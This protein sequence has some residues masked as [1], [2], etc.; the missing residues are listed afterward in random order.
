MIHITDGQTDKI[1][2][3]ITD[4][5]ILSNNHRQSLKDM[6]ETFEFETF[7][8]KPFSE[9]LGDHNRVV[10][11]NEDRGYTEFVIHEAAKFRDSNGSL[12]AEV[13]AS[14]SY[15]L[16][17]KA[18]VIE[19]QTLS[20]YTPS[21]AAS[22]TVGDTEWRT[23]TIEGSGYRTFHIENHTNPFALLKR[24]AREFELE[25]RFRVEVDGNRITGRFVDLLERVGK[26]RG[27]EVEFGRD[28]LGIRR[29]EKTDNIVTALVGL[30]PVREDG[31]RLEVLVEDQEALARWG[32]N[33]QHL[34]EVYEPQSTRSDMTEEELTQ[35]TRTELDKRINAVVEYESD[36]A[37]LEN[38]PGMENKKIR[39]GDTIKIKD[40]KFNPP[41]YLEARVHTQ[42]RDIVDKSNKHVE[43]GDF[44]EYTEEEVRSIWQELQ[45]EIRQKVSEYD[46]VEYTY[47]KGEIDQKDEGVYLDG[48]QY[49]D[50]V[51]ETAEERAKRHAEEEAKREAEE[52][53]QRAKEY[54]VAKE[55]YDAK[56]AEL[57][58]DIADKTDFEYVDGQ[59]VLK[60]DDSRV[61]A[62]DSTVGDLETTSNNLLQRV[63]DNEDELL[64][65]DGRITTVST[66]VD[67]VEGTL[68]ATITDLSNLDD[69]VSQ[70]QTSIDANA[71]AIALKASQDD[72]DTVSGD[73]SSISSELEV[74]AGR[75]D[76]KAEQSS[77]ENLEG[78]VTSVS[79]DL[80]ELSVDVDG[81]STNV[82]SL[83]AEVDG[84]EIGGRNLL[85]NSDFSSGLDRWSANSPSSINVVSEGLE[86]DVQHSQVI[87]RQ[88]I[89]M[90]ILQEDKLT[91]QVKIKIGNHD[92]L[93][94]ISF[95]FANTLTLALYKITDLGDGWKQYIFQ[96]EASTNYDFSG[97]VGLFDIDDDISFIINEI[98]LEKGNRATDWTPAPEDVDDAII[99]VEEYASSI[100]QKADSI[101]IDVNSL[102]QI[103]DDHGTQISEAN[104]NIT[105][106]SDEIDLRVKTE[107]YQ[108]DQDGVINRFESNEANITNLGDAIELRVERE[109]FEKR[110][111]HKVAN[112][113]SAGSGSYS[114]GYGNHITVTKDTQIASCTIYS[115]SPSSTEIRL[116]EGHG[117][118]GEIVDRIQVDLE[119]GENRVDI[120]FVLK[121]NQGYYTMYGSGGSMFRSS[122][123]SHPYETDNFSVVG[124]TANGDNFYYY[125][126]D[127]LISEG[128][129]RGVPQAFTAIESNA[130]QIALRAEKTELDT[131]NQSLNEAWA[132]LSI[133]SDEID[134]RVEK[135]GVIAAFN[136]SPESALLEAERIALDG[137]VEAKHIKSLEG[138][139]VNDQFVVDN[140]G[141]VTFAGNLQ[142]AS[143]TFHGELE[144][145]KVI[146]AEIEGS[147]FNTSGSD[148]EIRIEGDTIE[149]YLGDMESIGDRR[150]IAKLSSGYI[151]VF[152]ELRTGEN[153]VSVEWSTR[154]RD[155]E[156]L[157]SQGPYGAFVNSYEIGFGGSSLQKSGLRH[158]SREN[159]VLF[160][161]AEGRV[162]V[163]GTLELTDLQ[164]TDTSG[165][166]FDEYGNMWAGET[167][168]DLANWAFLD[169]DGDRQMTIRYGSGRDK[170]TIFHKDIEV[171]QSVTQF[172]M[173]NNGRVAFVDSSGNEILGVRDE[174]GGDNNS[175][176]RLPGLETYTTSLSPNL[177][178]SSANNV[179]RSTSAKKYKRDIEPIDDWYAEQFFNKA[180]PSWYRSK[181]PSDPK[182]HGYYGYIADDVAEFEPRLATYGE[183]GEP[184]GF[185][186]DRVPALLHVIQ[187]KDRKRITSVEEDIDRIGYDVNF[188]KMENELLKAEINKMKEGYNEA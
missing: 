10:I 139:N 7:A 27:R 76:L 6:L 162:I 53:E 57:V 140:S 147:A 64:D 96:N 99:S 135:N 115:D 95:R 45:A 49:T 108:A 102:E 119:E 85:R 128:I 170:K 143:G 129:G 137:Y 163:D 168:T 29:T 54:A 62:I 152:E 51:A 68:N 156:L 80:S 88:D 63:S 154:I 132:E 93:E 164:F 25:L 182:H 66:H 188:L 175:S 67:D 36:I 125:F 160:S 40:T 172:M 100:D 116:Y 101:I 50:V 73:V 114:S 106:L 32:R 107:D 103:T 169:Y 37:D 153:T 72:L 113:P 13:Y 165:I 161:E 171:D 86:V 28:L 180:Q 20:E 11:L 17:K 89:S 2:D 41:L 130:D 158:D 30:G 142:G 118:S 19:P 185:N 173:P 155:G 4:K 39:F 22:F 92:L 42:D 181:C 111:I 150:N 148:G 82:S 33:G 9:H 35:Y 167:A 52:A 26:W 55:E 166:R 98:K 21:T 141:N 87:P 184:E 44:I 120:N 151:E 59:L 24:I 12:Q 31:T 109:E 8:D 178:V 176:I 79:N 61:D 134:A 123:A 48:T 56:V 94:G 121:A 70:Q 58:S 131:T 133:Q 145:A 3:D 78:D 146:G 84:F 136:L 65:H 112:L 149:Q 110:V 144:G 23:G 71:S 16:L 127:L 177:Y 91:A 46:L 126:Y 174:I 74:Q 159:L 14:A 117:T 77:L 15:L 83:Q 1:L 122:D 186:Y 69:T 105:A 124:T 60:A 97:V 179:I 138:L 104:S 47:D 157:M 183:N 81:I 18:K 38:V 5:Y 34:I 187:R 43:L 90:R 75:I